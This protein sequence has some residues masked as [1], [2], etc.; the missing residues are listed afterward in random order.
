AA[1]VGSGY[2]FNP[3]L[4]LPAFSNCVAFMHSI[5]YGSWNRANSNTVV[6]RQLH[7]LL[8]PLRPQ[9]HCPHTSPTGGMTCV[10]FP[11]S[12]FYTTDLFDFTQPPG[13]HGGHGH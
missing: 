7:S 11:Y 3:G 6:C 9:V 5:P 12:S 2:Q 8:T 1:Y 13:A 4:P 10:D